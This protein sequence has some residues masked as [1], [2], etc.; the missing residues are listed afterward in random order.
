MGGLVEMEF[1]SEPILPVNMFKAQVL[2]LRTLKF[3]DAG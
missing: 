3:D 2:K 1:N